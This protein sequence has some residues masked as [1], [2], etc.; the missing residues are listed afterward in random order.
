MKKYNYKVGIWGQFGD[1]GQIA[2]GQAVRTTII[3]REIMDRY[4][5]ESV[6]ILNTNKWYRNP[7]SFFVKSVSLVINCKKVVIFPA[8]NGFKVIVPILNFVNMIYK[9][10]LYYVVIGG[11]LPSLLKHSPRY[12]KTLNNFKALFVQTENLKNDLES[13]GI[14]N[15][16]I[17]SN[18]KRL[19][20]ISE[21]ELKIKNK[22]NISVCTFSRVTHTKGIE[23]AILGVEKANQ[24]LGD[25]F[26]KLDIYGMIDKKYDEKFK[27]LLLENCGFVSYKGIVDYDK[28]VDTLK[29]YFTLIFPTFFPGEGFPGNIIDSFYSGLPIIA[30]DWLYNK[31]VVIDNLNGIIVPINS[32][33]A[34]SEALVKLYEDREMAFKISLNNLREAEKY[35]PSNILKKFFEFLDK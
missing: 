27:E 5:G 14:T 34:I 26:F 13:L 10:E 28:T 22:E 30:T 9:R 19:E 29:K 6:K 3:T 17:L 18:L 31:D 23:D 35:T 16:Y 21:S 12:I 1:G 33:E 20:R 2:D 8:N 4:G 11:F 24:K 32:P 15:V 7:V 25:K